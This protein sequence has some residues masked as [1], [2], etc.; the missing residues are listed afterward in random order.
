[1][2]VELARIVY[3]CMAL[4]PVSGAVVSAWSGVRAVRG[5]RIDDHRRWMNR[6]SLWIVA[7]LVSYL[8]KLLL[9]GREPLDTWGPER[10]RLLY[11]HRALVESM[12][13]VGIV[14]RILGPRGLAR[15]GRTRSMHRG[16]GRVALGAATLGFGT[17]VAVLVG[18]ILAA[19]P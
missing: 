16:F 2:S 11:V 12:L 17:A 14:A 9:L 3:W 7:F 5:G 4:V 18:M 19:A 13:I 10:L 8:V 1:M 6:A 15:G